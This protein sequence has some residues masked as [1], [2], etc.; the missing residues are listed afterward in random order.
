MYI[1]YRSLIYKSRHFSLAHLTSRVSIL[2]RTS[3]EARSYTSIIQSL[4][5]RVNTFCIS[6]E[7]IVYFS[8]LIEKE[9]YTIFFSNLAVPPILT[10]IHLVLWVCGEL[11]DQRPDRRFPSRFPCSTIST[12]ASSIHPSSFSD[13]R[14]SA[15]IVLAL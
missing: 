10:S 7:D 14:D 5:Q 4:Y 6:V 9:V 11:T 1:H 12:C 8:H 2:E 15:N 13:E 3:A